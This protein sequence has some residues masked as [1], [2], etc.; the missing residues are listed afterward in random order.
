MER[1][2]QKVDNSYFP[3]ISRLVD[4]IE[5]SNPELAR[6]SIQTLIKKKAVVQLSFN[7]KKHYCDSHSHY[8]PNQTSKF[9]LESLTI[10]INCYYNHMFCNDCIY[11][12]VKQK[13]PS[14]CLEHS[15]YQC[16]ACEYNQV[17]YTLL[18]RDD[19]LESVF[20]HLYGEQTINGI[21][22]FNPRPVINQ[23]VNA[24]FKCN[25]TY[26]TLYPICRSSHFSCSECAEAWANTATQVKC[27]VD[28]CEEDAY[29]LTIIQALENS[30]AVSRL[31]E[32]FK[33][34]GYFF[35][36][37]PKCLLL[38]SLDYKY[39]T[40][41]CRCGQEI[42]NNCERPA[43]LETCFFYEST[44]EFEII[45]LPAPEE[46]GKPKNLR[47]QE[48]LN[49]KYAFE[50]FLEDQGN[51]YYF[52]SA[53]LI[54]NKPLE[55]RYAAK[56]E[57]MIQECGGEDKVGEVYIWH[58]SSGT[59]YPA[60][61]NEGLKVGGVDYGVGVAQG[62]RFGYGIY[63]S[64]TPDTPIT[65]AKGGKSIIACLAMKGIES[66]T[67]IND[68]KLLD[69]GTSHSFKPV[70]T[71]T[72]KNWWVFFTKEQVLPRFLVEFGP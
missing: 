61:M 63:S 71:D 55:V 10:P 24:C 15:Y 31:K 64:T 29:C 28:T 46:I 19:I 37:C 8:F 32:L 38:V 49:A 53:K 18:L 22:N 72:E 9:I 27:L 41:K 56:K 25:T 62:T 66:K 30:T 60:I 48:Y 13:F 26:K 54:V 58:G 33:I 40:S 14:C 69:M 47:E 20:N 67:I 4:S 68:P 59:N 6:D 36:T 34:K 70:A 35:N 16:I 50:H 51:T 39:K 45:D 1:N 5:C 57:K 52:K 7:G 43:H 44:Q 3:E 21:R 65:Y 42:C 17:P 2:I 23:T 11:K 12:Y